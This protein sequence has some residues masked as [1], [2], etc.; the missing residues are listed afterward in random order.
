MCSVSVREI[1][2]WPEIVL[3]CDYQE[4][5]FGHRYCDEY[6]IQYTI[7]LEG[8]FFLLETRSGGIAIA[9][10]TTIGGARVE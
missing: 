2:S 3:Q 1:L 6:T 8:T 7:F 4:I 9:P 5:Q 10:P